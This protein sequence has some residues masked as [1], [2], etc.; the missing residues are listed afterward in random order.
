MAEDVHHIRLQVD[1][2]AGLAKQALELPSAVAQM[3]SGLVHAVPALFG[4]K[5]GGLGVLELLL[6][7]FQAAASYFLRPSAAKEKEATHE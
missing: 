1:E 6:A 5:D 7:G 4:K 2:V 3:M